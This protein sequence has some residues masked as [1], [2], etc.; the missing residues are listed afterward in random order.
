[1]TG[2]SWDPTLYSGAAAYYAVGRAAYP[3]ALATRL[4]GELGL[5]GSGRLLDVG[6]GPGSL[7]LLLAPLFAETTG[8]DADAEMLA[9][10]ARLAA[11]A[12]VSGV[13]WRHLRAEDLP[14]GL[15]TYRVV[16]FAQSFHWMNRARVAAA[17]HGMLDPDGACV[18]VHATTHQGVH[19]DRVLPHPQPPR[20]EIA[21]LVRRYLGPEQRAGQG[22]L[23][24]GTPG[25]EDDVYRTAGFVGPRRLSIPGTVLD[26]STDE[27]VAAVLSVSGSAPHLFG[28]R[29]AAFEADLRALLQATSPTGRFSQ[30]MREIAVDIWSP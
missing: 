27:V 9:L 12:G 7:T 23:S 13:R 1:M 22:I 17:V 6:C 16:S 11:A 2:W 26:R 29:L 10:A 25:R 14:A 28:A 21:A 18:H 20:A 24:Q 4:A 3:R 15:G 5:D 30:Q 8:V 19:T